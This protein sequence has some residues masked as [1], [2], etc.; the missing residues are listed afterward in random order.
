MCIRDR[1][2]YYDTLV[3]SPAVIETELICTTCNSSTKTCLT[4]SHKCLDENISLS[5]VYTNN[6][7]GHESSKSCFEASSGCYWIAVFGLGASGR[8]EERPLNVE[9]IQVNSETL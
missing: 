8:M 6:G 9:I 2:I 3:E 4:I 7:P 5:I 1:G